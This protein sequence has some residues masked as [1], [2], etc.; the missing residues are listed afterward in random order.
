MGKLFINAV[1]GS[2]STSKRSVK[3]FIEST[4]SL[5]CRIKGLEQRGVGQSLHAGYAFMLYWPIF[6]EPQLKEA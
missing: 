2:F 4:D 3:R 6:Q 5:C 1:L